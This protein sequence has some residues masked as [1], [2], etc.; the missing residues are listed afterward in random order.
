MKTSRSPKAARGLGSLAVRE[1]V[2]PP[3]TS[4]I[5]ERVSVRDVLRLAGCGEPNDRGFLTCP[6]HAERTPSFHII[7]D[8]GWRCFGCGRHG[9]ILDLVCALGLA[10]DR[11]SAAAL[12]VDAT[13]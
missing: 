6:L 13:R 1:A 10:G 12:L 5:V 2:T 3:F 11:A 7:G 9:G 4:S 8:R